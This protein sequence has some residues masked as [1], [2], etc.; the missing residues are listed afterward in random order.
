MDFRDKIVLVTGA[1]RGIGKGIAQKFA[2]NGATTI[3][4]DVNEEG[5][6]E[7]TQELKDINPQT[8]SIVFDVSEKEATQQAIKTIIQDYKRIDILV[9]NAGIARDALI[10]RAKKKDWDKVLSVNLTGVFN[11]C[12]AV[13][14]YM[15]KNQSGKII[16]ISSVIGMIGN[17][18]Q[19]TYSASKAGIIGLT[20][21]LAKELGSRGITVNAVAPGFIETEMTDALGESAQE[22][23]LEGVLIK[24]KGQPEDVANVVAFL[25]SE[26]ADYITGEV[27]KVD[28]GLAI[29]GI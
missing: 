13:S 20:K 8:D 17:K 3:L 2:H 28:G 12:K 9:N 26:S 23:F 11:T 18:G 14:R 19:A 22:K 15:L 21:S 10:M 16:N 24:R 1:A 5:L 6:A 29:A 25:A 7:T 4:S 27:I